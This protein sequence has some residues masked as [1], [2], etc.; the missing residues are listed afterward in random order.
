MKGID[1]LDY[2]NFDDWWD[3]VKAFAD[4]YNLSYTH[5][6]EEFVIDGVLFPVHLEF[7]HETQ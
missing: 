7:E 5:C 3:V 1:C 6:E 2:A 4:Q